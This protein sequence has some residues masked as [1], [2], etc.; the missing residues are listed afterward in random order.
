MKDNKAKEEK[1][2]PKKDFKKDHIS[3]PYKN[4]PISKV[5]YHDITNNHKYKL[6]F[7]GQ[8]TAVTKK[9]I[10]KYLS[11]E[12]LTEKEHTALDKK[13]NFYHKK[14]NV[15]FSENTK[16]IAVYYHLETNISIKMFQFLI[17]HL[18]KNEKILADKENINPSDFL[19]DNQLLYVYNI[20][21]GYKKIVSILNFIFK[22]DTELDNKDF[23]DRLLEVF[24]FSKKELIQRVKD[25]DSTVGFLDRKIYMYT[26]LLYNE[27][28]YKLALSLPNILTVKYTFNH[29]NTVYDYYKNHNIPSIIEKKD[30]KIDPKLIQGDDNNY[31]FNNIMDYN[32]LFNNEIHIMIKNDMKKIMKNHVIDFYFPE[33]DRYDLDLAQFFES[34]KK[35]NEE[36]DATID[37]HNTLKIIKNLNKNLIL[38]IYD[39]NLNLN[40]RINLDIIYNNFNTN[41][42]LPVIKYYIKN[43]PSNFKL[44][45]EFI[46]KH[47]YSEIDSLLRNKLHPKIK[48][49]LSNNY[50]QF[51]WRIEKGFL[52]TINLYDTG[53]IVSFFDNEKYMDINKYIIPYSRL[54]RATVKKIKDMVTLKIIPMPNIE[55]VFH[56]TA[57][58]IYY[59]N[60]ITSNLQTEFK[61]G[62]VLKIDKHSQQYYIGLIKRIIRD[63]YIQFIVS[64]STNNTL[65]LLYKQVNNFYNP[66]NIN[67]FI[68]RFLRKKNIA[69]NNKL[70]KSLKKFLK[71]TFMIS[72]KNIDDYIDNID[73]YE[74]KVE[75]DFLYGIEV[76]ILFL[77]D[78]IVQI[79]Y[80]TV[81]TF[82]SIKTINY[83]VDSIKK[84]NFYIENILRQT[85]NLSKIVS[86]DEKSISKS[87]TVGKTKTD[88]EFPTLDIGNDIEISNF[89]DNLDIDL[90]LDLELGFG[91]NSFIDNEFDKDISDIR[92][93]LD[94]KSNLEG[95]HEGEISVSGDRDVSVTKSSSD[96]IKGIE[97]QK[98]DSSKKYKFKE[99][100]KQ[101]RKHFDPNLFEV[102]GNN[103]EIVYSYGIKDCDNKQMRQPY[104]VTKQELDTY[105]PDALTGYI[106]YRNNYYICPRIWDVKANSPISVKKFIESGYKS[107]YNK[108]LPI[109][110]DKK[111]KIKLGDDYTVII[112]KGTT[113][114]YWEDEAVKDKLPSIL[115]GTERNAFPGLAKPSNHP[116]KLCVP[117]CF[118]KQPKDYDENKKEIQRFY[119]PNGF[120][121]C[122]MDDK[123]QEEEISSSSFKSNELHKVQ[124]INSFKFNCD[125]VTDF[126]I[127]GETTELD[128]CKFGLLPE[129]LDILLNNHQKLF[130]NKTNSN[131]INKCNVFLKR[132]INKNNIKYNFLETWSVVIK[133]SLNN[134]IKLMIRNLTPQLFM[135]LNNGELVNIYSASNL[136]PYSV[137]DLSSF[138]EFCK[139]YPEFLNIFDFDYSV[140]EELDY[141]EFEEIIEKDIELSRK[142]IIIYKIFRAFYNYIS[143]ILNKD[144]YKNYLHFIDFLTRPMEW[145]K[146]GINLVLFDAK[147]NNIICNPYTRNS[148]KMAIFIMHSPFKFI[149]VVNYEMIGKNNIIK[150]I[151][152]INHA[153]FNKEFIKSYQDKN[154]NINLLKEAANRKPALLK[155]IGIHNE[156]CININT[157]VVN[158]LKALGDLV[159]VD[160]KFINNSVQI[161]FIMLSTVMAE[162]GSRSSSDSSGTKKIQKGGENK[163]RPK[164]TKLLIPIYPTNYFTIN[165]SKRISFLR[166]KHYCT[167][168]IYLELHALCNAISNT[169]LLKTIGK[170]FRIYQDKLKQ[171]INLFKKYD[172]KIAKVFYNPTLKKIIGVKFKNNLVAPIIP[173]D[174]TDKLTKDLE[175]LDESIL[176]ESILY[177]FNYSI[178]D[179][180][181][182]ITNKNLFIN[183]LMYNNF[184]YQ[185]SRIIMLTKNKNYY[186]KIKN[187]VTGNNDKDKNI[188]ASYNEV[189]RLMKEYVLREGKFNM[190][191]NNSKNNKK[192][193][194][195]KTKKRDIMPGYKFRKVFKTKKTLCEENPLMDIEKKD[196]YYE[197]KLTLD[198]AKFK[199]F[200]Y[201]L[202]VDLNINYNEFL[203]IINGHF[204][205]IFYENNTIFQNSNDIQITPEELSKY[206]ANG[207]YSNYKKNIQLMI[208]KDNK[209]SDK[210]TNDSI[211]KITG[212]LEKL[213]EELNKGVRRLIEPSSSS[214]KGLSNVL[215][216]TVFDKDGVYDK[217]KHFGICK[218]PFIKNNRL[219]DKCYQDDKDRGM[220]CPI[221]LDNNAKPTKYGYCPSKS[222]NDDIQQMKA[223]GDVK[224]KKFMNGDCLM[225]HLIKYEKNGKEIIK[226]NYSCQKLVSNNED[227]SE[228]DSTQTK[229]MTW[230]PLSKDFANYDSDNQRL[231][232]KAAINSNDIDKDPKE[233]KNIISKDNI[234]PK[235]INYKKKGYCQPYIKKD[236]LTKKLNMLEQ[237][238]YKPITLETYNPQKCY[239][240]IKKDGYSKIQLYNFGKNILDIA[241]E[242]M[243]KDDIIVKKDILCNLINREFRKRKFKKDQITN[244]DRIKAYTKDPNNCMESENKGGYYKKD[245]VEMAINYFNLNENDAGR[246]SKKDL[247]TYLIPKIKKIKKELE[248]TASSVSK[249]ISM[250][251]SHVNYYYP[252]NLAKCKDVPGRG[253]FNIR[254]LKEIALKNFNIDIKGRSKDELCDLIEDKVKTIQ[255]DNDRDEITILDKKEIDSILDDDY[256]DEKDTYQDTDASYDDEIE[257]LMKYDDDPIIDLDID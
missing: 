245:L 191:N 203:T 84:I 179:E 210:L 67:Q 220:I 15:E 68:H 251:S 158:F 253:G 151:F 11:G 208:T 72:E 152:D 193:N 50:L 140:V 33:H 20:K 206:I 18:V 29:N 170:K 23:I 195:K 178:N 126:Y 28:F 142:I 91:D 106:K 31:L 59:S 85:S 180:F 88:S 217:N 192:K 36:I 141:N 96:L 185:F 225:P 16:N 44:N 53:Y 240:G 116:N 183:D 45:K 95:L 224:N 234:M 25:T 87:K 154:K 78:N 80:D 37:E 244:L 161:E 6:I 62:Y 89:G 123:S 121:K 160:N 58:K 115:K 169:E 40:P 232:I 157:K 2:K 248:S 146:K 136:L 238:N 133:Q 102:K 32:R 144:E 83:Y 130:L 137:K 222:T 52:L 120:E 241:P 177:D 5:I 215:Y 42:Y 202:A 249:S 64:D 117:C 24:N 135:D 242:N 34:Y 65:K 147:S 124:E 197:C 159:D 27:S 205:P 218:F 162:E 30:T 75:S 181:L 12:K 46:Q 174:L 198:G 94:L 60:I 254:K 110:I 201:L 166:S 171:I 21:I 90:D 119:K 100:M 256:Q 196:D 92:D 207:L 211:K 186:K 55:S 199:Y 54:I 139:S 41:K 128:K 51:K 148:N 229:N 230:C 214:T 247:C 184:K 99:Y 19:P 150:G 149:P 4:I 48:N 97:V 73:N 43:E 111:N 233:I 189:F 82:E 235:Y 155:I 22:N 127:L 175:K 70:I 3:A 69:I 227:K 17:Y 105:D 257:R 107:P 7:V 131:L 122:N 113:D 250:T 104:I 176:I 219:S 138:K 38:D 200:C 101:M 163:N 165:D 237:D 47:D 9:I 13:I 98:F 252:G 93:L 226:I 167:L 145:Q 223:Y 231:Y 173:I 164:D 14:M 182:K 216:T 26:D 153:S 190:D 8:Q 61:H 172:Y 57:G 204:V 114:T 213:E 66:D 125:M 143:H 187:I 132:G 76:T 194:T 79:N 112:R 239:L 77:P 246:M 212:E 221:E 168:D 103:G 39:N 188:Q 243:M 71:K 118:K 1:D 209:Y 86:E 228:S 56:D 74:P 81:E 35:F 109:P 236:K 108:G 49:L 10:N 156:H 63:S 129:N 134:L 255:L